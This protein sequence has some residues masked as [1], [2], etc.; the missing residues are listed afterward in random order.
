MQTRY[1]AWPSLLPGWILSH[2]RQSNMYPT[3]SCLW[4]RQSAR[5]APTTRTQPQLARSPRMLLPVCA[6][7][8]HNNRCVRTLILH[9]IS[10]KSLN[11][12]RKAYRTRQEHVPKWVAAVAPGGV[13]GLVLAKEHVESLPK[14]RQ[15]VDYASLMRRG[16]QAGTGGECPALLLAPMEVLADRCFRCRTKQQ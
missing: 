5:P 16:T 11:D 2:S 6:P 10:S 14:P 8:G 9:K 12:F 13:R 15:G 3:G 1:I 7:L 4:D